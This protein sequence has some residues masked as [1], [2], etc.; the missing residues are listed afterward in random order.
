MTI[1]SF[2][3]ALA[4]AVASLLATAAQATVFDFSFTGP[5][6]GVLGSFNATQTSPGSNT[7]LIDTFLPQSM[8][9][10]RAT[11]PSFAYILPASVAGYRTFTYNVGSGPSGT[12]TFSI[13]NTGIG[14]AT[15][16]NSFRIAT[17]SGGL[18]YELTSSTT[19][20]ANTTG[21][22]TLYQSSP[23]VVGVPGPVAGAG[24]PALLALGGIYG[25]GRWRA[26][27]GA[28]A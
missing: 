8:V 15:S 18:F 5:G 2:R 20:A 14:F 9:S 4:F 26:R 13:G 7:Y 27:R 17:S 25:F 6:A 23:A 24:L 22:F 3:A 11:S 12:D 21:V 16:T 10:S 19:P 28:A 1:S